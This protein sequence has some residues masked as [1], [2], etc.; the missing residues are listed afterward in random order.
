MTPT[1]VQAI[2]AM[3]APVVLIT[4]TAILSGGIQSVYGSVNDRMRAMT[5]ER[6]ELV[7][8]SGGQIGVVVDLAPAERERVTQ[9]DSQLPLL[10]RRHRLLRD[11][12]LVLYLGAVILV[13][14]VIVLGAAVTLGSEGVGVAAL[15]LVLVGTSASLAGLVLAARSILV[16]QDAIDYEVGRTL[17]LGA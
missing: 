5:R 6:L 12:V 15:C 7:T 17:S 14:S 13:V 1:A 8:Q 3:V 10:L 2:Q 9:I 16:S 11:C 4:A